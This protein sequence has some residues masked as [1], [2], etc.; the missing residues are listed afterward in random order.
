MRKQQFKLRNTCDRNSKLQR[1]GLQKLAELTHQNTRLNEGR[2]PMNKV[3][4]GLTLHEETTISQQIKMLGIGNGK[5]TNIFTALEDGR[6]TLKLETH[7]NSN[8]MSLTATINDAI[9]RKSQTKLNEVIESDN[10]NFTLAIDNK[11]QK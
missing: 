4:L 3:T 10:G 7:S 11:F 9:Q 1:E 8:W 2:I 6:E 5:Y